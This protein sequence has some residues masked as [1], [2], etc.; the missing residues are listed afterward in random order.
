MHEGAV[1]LTNPAA[2]IMMAMCGGGLW[3]NPERGFINRQIESK[4]AQGKDPDASRRF[5]RA[6]A[7]G[8]CVDS[9]AL[10]ILRDFMCLHLGTAHE[11]WDI[12]DVPADRWFRD[13]WRRSHNGGPILVDLAKARRIQLEKIKAAVQAHNHPRLA[14]GRRPYLPLWGELGN[15]IRHARDEEELRRVW[16]SGL[17]RRTSWHGKQ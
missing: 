9:E 2:Q 11:V 10:G 17:C 8:G 12:D 15:A 1:A 16:P 7:F 6:L 5:C 14:L 4:I 13:A 3:R